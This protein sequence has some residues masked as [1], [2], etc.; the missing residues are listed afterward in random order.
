MKLILH[1]FGFEK[2]EHKEDD[3]T[4]IYLF[5]P[6]QAQLLNC[7]T[8]SKKKDIE[9][10]PKEKFNILSNHANFKFQHRFK[11]E[12]YPE[13]KTKINELELINDK[14]KTDY[15]FLEHLHKETL[16][17]NKK[18]YEDLKIESNELKLKYDELNLEYDNLKNIFN[19]INEELE[20]FK[21]K[22]REEEEL[23]QRLLQE[24]QELKQRLLQEQQEKQQEE[25]QEQ[26]EEPQ[27][28][29]EEPK[30]E[31]EPIIIVKKVRKTRKLRKSKTRRRNKK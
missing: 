7:L 23:K 27:E 21:T 26:Q 2:L 13:N 19:T 24:E 9:F 15:L 5:T 3:I 29:Q 12:Y 4:H 25:Q 16:E 31:E 17:E 6:N 11:E 18:L 1:Y 14:L 20:I 28:Q 10:T 30:Q 22:Q 8:Q